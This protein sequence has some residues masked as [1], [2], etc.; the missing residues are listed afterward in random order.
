MSL[1]VIMRITS[2][3]I[4]SNGV[5]NPFKAWTVSFNLES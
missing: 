1:I 4:G 3:W 2:G 5:N